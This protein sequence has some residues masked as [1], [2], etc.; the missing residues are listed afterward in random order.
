MRLTISPLAEMQI[1]AVRLSGETCGNRTL[2]SILRRQILVALADP[3]L[4][5][6]RKTLLERRDRYDFS[7]IRRER[8]G[9]NGRIF[10]VVA[11]ANDLT[12]VLAV[13]RKLDP[14]DP[15]DAYRELSEALREGLFDDAFAE[16]GIP[17]PA[18]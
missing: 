4:A 17:K 13:G 9:A 14:S 8:F 18:G 7:G 5:T 15:A 10:Y 16:L 2:F 1:A 6:R 11:P 12:I 3:E